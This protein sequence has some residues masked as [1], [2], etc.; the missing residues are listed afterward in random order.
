[1]WIISV[2]RPF[3]PC[4]LF[5]EVWLSNVFPGTAGR[6]RRS[7]LLHFAFLYRFPVMI[8]KKTKQREYSWDKRSCFCCFRDC[9]YYNT[10]CC[11][12]KEKSMDRIDSNKT[13]RE[14]QS[15]RKMF[16]ICSYSFR[17][18]PT[19]FWKINLLMFSRTIH[20]SSW[21]YSV[22]RQNVAILVPTTTKNKVKVK[23]KVN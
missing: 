3:S 11:D 21:S 2:F 14:T 7:R 4:G 10:D 20:R 12:D 15:L 23:V 17:P 5:H 1:M 13:V 22:V 16:I 18:L 9:D 19:K 8:K 6:L